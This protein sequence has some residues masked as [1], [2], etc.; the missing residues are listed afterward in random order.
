[1]LVV[2]AHGEAPERLLASLAGTLGARPTVWVEP[3]PWGSLLIAD[4]LHARSDRWL[5]AGRP[6]R[7]PWGLPLGDFPLDE[8]L[9]EYDRYGV[10]AA[11]LGSGPFLV[12]DLAGGRL[13]RTP[14]GIVPA[15][16]GMG[17]CGPVFATSDRVLR[18]LAREVREIA[19]GE[20]AG[21]AGVD[22]IACLSSDKQHEQL[23]LVRWEWL[24]EEITTRVARL[25]RLARVNLPGAPDAVADRWL[26]RTAMGDVVFAPSL[27]RPSGRTEALSYS[28]AAR[29]WSRARSAG[30]WLFAPTVERPVRDIA[31]LMA[32]GVTARTETARPQQVRSETARVG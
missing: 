12:I 3:M 7:D 9:A 21:P 11:H 5:V 27:R 30:L 28:V 18:M 14:S 8:A 22:G 10:H 26:S 23:R 16:R 25:G 17:T 32:G 31:A 13:L 24:D 15:F 2:V 19:P 1:M 20:I 4:A 6:Q 29:A